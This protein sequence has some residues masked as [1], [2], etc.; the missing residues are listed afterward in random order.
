MPEDRRDYSLQSRV[1]GELVWP[2]MSP[3]ELRHG[4]RISVKDE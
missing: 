4:L 3:S 1:L 2:R